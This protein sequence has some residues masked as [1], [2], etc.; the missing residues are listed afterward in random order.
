MKGISMKRK[1]LWI[2]FGAVM[3]FAALGLTLYPVIS[4]YVNRKYASEIYTAYQEAI[5]QTDDTMLEQERDRAAAYNQALISGNGFT[6]DALQSASESYDSILN[7]AGD[8]IM[9]YVEIP[10]ISVRLPIY[11]G[12]GDSVL[13]KGVGHLLGSSLPI[14][15]G[16]TH[17]ILSGHSGMASQ[18]MFTDLEQLEMGDMFYL[19]VL[20]DVLAYQV[21]EINTV[22]PTD[23]SLLGIWEGQDNCTLVTCTPYGINTHRLLVTGKRI[24]DTEAEQIADGAETADSTGSHW[25]QYY[26]RGLEIGLAVVFGLLTVLILLYWLWKR[27]QRRKQHG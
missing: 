1:I 14:G 4:N 26:L 20:G 16:S 8:G 27:L 18:T 9:G 25:M 10:K 11:H 19:R 24:E 22:L 2:I 17:S 13:R 6:Q 15:G 12:T 3:F 21:F 5:A 23:T 7:L